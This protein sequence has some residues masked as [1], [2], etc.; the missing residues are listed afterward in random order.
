MYVT[1]LGGYPD[2]TTKT[3]EHREVQGKMSLIE[4]MDDRNNCKAKELNYTL[5]PYILVFPYCA[6][7]TLKYPGD[8]DINVRKGKKEKK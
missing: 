2:T 5:C 6:L 1:L 7:P 3:L 4:S 8:T